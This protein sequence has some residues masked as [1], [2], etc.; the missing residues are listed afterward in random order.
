MS[1]SNHGTSKTSSIYLLLCLIVHSGPSLAWGE[2]GHDLITRIA[3]QNLKSQSTNNPAIMKPFASRDHM[4][5]HLS[6]TPDIVW[7]APY[8]SKEDRA[9]N[10]P[11]HFINLEKSYDEIASVNDIDRDF[12][13]YAKRASTK[14]FN[15]AKDAGTAPWR[16]LQLY[17]LM[18]TALKQAGKANNNDDMISATNDALLYAGLMSH[19]IGDLANPH[20]TTSNHDGQLTGNT[21]LHAYFESDVVS[22]LPMK[23]A[24]QID[25]TSKASLLHKTIF[26]NKSKQDTKQ[27]LM[28]PQELVFGLVFNSFSNVDKLRKLDDRYSLIEKSTEKRTRAK[29]KPPESVAKHYNRFV[30]ERLSVGAAVLSQLWFLAWQTAGEPDLSEYRSYHYPVKAE[31]IKPNYIE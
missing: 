20:H 16:A 15:A 23:L 25:R 7:R 30:I 3:V 10:Y 2:R 6:N 27:L 26:K 5:S 29:R 24:S 8:M 31:F 4:L 18:S 19:F 1:E 12:A 21:G 9:E 14:G 11:T 28:D 17:D 13:S 22:V